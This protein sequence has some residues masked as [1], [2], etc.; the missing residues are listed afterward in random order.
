MGHVW[1]RD[2]L[3]K[4]L[5]SQA[6]EPMDTFFHCTGTQGKHRRTGTAARYGG[7]VGA[8]TGGWTADREMIMI[9]MIARRARGYVCTNDI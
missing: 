4:W 1:D 9:T 7:C 2:R 3:G 5:R 8:D 6:V